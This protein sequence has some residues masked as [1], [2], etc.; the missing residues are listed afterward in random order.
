MAAG[1]IH[2]QIGGGFARYSV[3]AEWLVPHFEKM[4]YD[5]AQLLSLYTRAWL[6]TGRDRYRE[7]VAEIIGWLER[8]MRAPGGGYHA[9]LD[10]DSEGVEGKFYVWSLDEVTSVLTPDELDFAIHHYGITENG[11]F[12]GESIL[13]VARPLGDLADAMGMAVDEATAL[14]DRVAAKLL[15]A[16]SQRVRPGTDTKVIVAW[17]AMLVKALAEAGMAFERADWIALATA[18]AT[19]LVTQARSDSGRLGRTIV[20]GRP[21]GQGVLEDYASLADALVMLYR[22]TADLRWLNIAGELVDAIQNDFAHSS[23]I[24]FFD[25]ASDHEALIVRP[26]D[27]QDG[28]LP[29]GNAMALDAMLSIARL[30]FDATME[31][32]VRDVLASLAAPMSQHPAAFGRFLAV[33]ERTLA[34]ETTVVIGGDAMSDAAL[35]LRVSIFRQG[36]P[37]VDLAYTAADPDGRWPQL[38]DRPIPPGTAAAAFVC[39]GTVCLPPVTSA[40]ALSMILDDAGT[41]LGDDRAQGL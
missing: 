23:G 1:G 36:N 30:R 14:R 11:N 39:R 37:F 26:R 33:L 27:L 19:T 16:R 15:A 7:V 8:E 40:D 32:R 17:N 38:A 22:A 2:D 3:D 29:S 9:A 34:D 13:F 20:D 28:A 35:S 4:L 10:A 5:N 12:E 21:S 6:L 31:Q 41:M 18:T 25:T 24:G